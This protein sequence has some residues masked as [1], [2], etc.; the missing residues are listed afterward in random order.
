MAKNEAKIK[1]TAQTGDFN[2]AI[3][4]SNDEISKLNAE[5]KLNK[6]QMDGAGKSVEALEDK[7]A[8]LEKQLKASQ[9]KTEALAQKLQKAR[10]I[11]GDNSSEVTKLERQ[12]AN[13]ETAEEKCKQA[14]NACNKELEEQK[15]AANK[16]ESAT[17]KLTS[18]MN[19]QESELAEL[20][21]KYTDLAIEGKDTSEEAQNL[22]R[23]IEELSSELK[24]NK[25]AFDNASNKAN[26]LDKSFDDVKDGS[27][28]AGNGFTVLKGVAANLV[29]EGLNAIKDACG[30]VIE[31]FNEVDEGADNAIKATGA[32]GAEADRLTASYEKVAS[33]VVG[34]FADIGSALGEVNTRFGYTGE[35][36]ENCATDFL[37]F[38]EITGVDSTEAVQSVSRALNDAGIPLDEYGTLLDQLAKAGQAAGIDV[39]S[40]TDGLS[41]NGAT[42]R[43]MGFNTEETI[44]LLSQFELSGAD[45]SQMLV[46]MKKAMTNWAKSGKDGS[47]EFAKT[48]AGIKDGSIT[49]A[50][51]I[52]IFG[53][54]AG[55]QLVDAIKSG[56]FEYQDM[57]GVIQNSSGSLDGTFDELIDGGYDADLAVQKAKLAMADIGDTVL[58]TVSP[59]FDNITNLL[60]VMADNFSKAVEWGT[61][62]KGVLIAIATVIGIVATAIGLY[63]VV[64]AVKTAMDAAQVGTVWA[65]VAAHWAQAT[66]AMAAIAPYLLIVA[67]IAAVIAIIVL[68][69]KYWD[70][71]VAAVQN[72]IEKI[73]SALT[74][75]GEWIN[76]KFNAFKNTVSN[77]FNGIKSTASNV[78]NGIKNTISNVVNGIKSTVTNVFNNIKD[79]I[80]RPINAAKDGVSKAIGKIK[81]LFSNLK[82]KLPDIK[83]PHFSI[84]GK[85]SLD[86]PSVPKLKIDWY[87]NGAI[88]TKPTL[89]NTLSGIKGVGEAGAEAVLPIA[90]L[91][92]YIVNAIDRTANVINLEPLADAIERIANRPLNL[93]INGK[94]FA[95][96]TATDT[97]DVNGL[98]NSFKSRGLAM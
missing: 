29:T 40:L 16:T 15:E 62:H 25:T 80:M 23:Q 24:Q 21:R 50:N 13:A 96:A 97:D 4:K 9:D 30:E 49:A 74:T 66:A 67:A 6:T 53:T 85:F 68:C 46:G 22:A 77:I 34:D 79:A 2:N 83:L 64:Q 63:N 5:L 86:P 65:L 33:T 55:P 95:E 31:A 47:T 89:F 94:R 11:F 48:V 41:K 52:E 76:T 72:A 12:L 39:T 26:K 73:K 43:A 69:I 38:S 8:L 93:D 60:S 35:K 81:E 54:K 36:L 7:H 42:M 10:E 28:K 51:A 84:S 90:K 44:A 45:S 91:E 17:D 32:T 92:E 71:I 27:E 3:K 18:K 82:L 57:L 78:W 1:F 58:T 14:I 37:K 88:F 70:N 98:R 56:K 19:E 59:A 75:I 61:Q 20:K 87:A